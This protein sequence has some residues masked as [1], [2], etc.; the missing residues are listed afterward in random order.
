ME[1]LITIITN[2]TSLDTR[3]GVYSRELQILIS[4]LKSSK[5]TN[6]KNVCRLVMDIKR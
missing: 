1:Q 4:K 2:L 6:Y 3:H 5:F